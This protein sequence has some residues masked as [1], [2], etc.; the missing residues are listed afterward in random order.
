MLTL[1]AEKRDTKIKAEKIRA[2]GRVPAILYG[3]KVSPLSISVAKKEFVSLWKDA[4]ESSVV[5]LEG[6][7]IDQEILIHDVSVH[8]V[9]EEP[10]HVD[11]YAI[12][13][14]KTVTVSVPLDFVGQEDAPAV[15]NLGAT[16][17]KVLHEL[18]IE[19]LPSKLPHS[20]EVDV[21]KLSSLD[22]QIL[23]KDLNL[24]EGVKATLDPEEV[25]IAV[26]EVK[27]EV[28]EEPTE[29]DMSSIEVEQK[30]KAEEEPGES[31]EESSGKKEEK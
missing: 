5:K 2:E 22:S 30:G 18:E 31:K 17:V 15:K 29:I 13:K 23:V 11:F 16:L 8:P 27:E 10:V 26:A 25:V 14:G 12:E 28:E 4:G 19:S 3:R 1:K 6:P 7:G 24:P 9:S 20:I 21:S